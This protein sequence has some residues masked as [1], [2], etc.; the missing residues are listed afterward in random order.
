MDAIKNKEA[1]L[2]RVRDINYSKIIDEACGRWVQ[3]QPAKEKQC[4]SI[5]VDSSWNKRSYQGLDFYVVDA[6]AVDSTNDIKSVYWHYGLGIT[7]SEILEN[8]AAELEAKVTKDVLDQGQADIILVDGSLASRFV[9]SNAD[10]VMKFVNDIII[11]KKRQREE[12]EG[13]KE[14]FVVF[15]SKNSDTMKQ[16]KSLKALAADMYYYNHIGGDKVGFSIPFED[17]GRFGSGGGSTKFGCNIVEVYVRLRE[18]APIIKI[19]LIGST[20]E[21][22]RESDI[23][24]IIDTLYYHSVSGYPYCLKLAHNNCKVSNE[25]LDRLSSIYNLKNESSARAPLNE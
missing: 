12:Q 7:R 4:L 22:W 18:Y 24:N 13:K 19:E 16:F 20:R 5:G 11:A 17:N 8:K 15:I 10:E 1:I 14:L 2:S 3:Y 21:E 25:D 6:V 9:N 23:K